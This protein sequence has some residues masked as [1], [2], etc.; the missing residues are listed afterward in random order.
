MKEK[1][2]MCLLQM[3]FGGS[4]REIPQIFCTVAQMRDAAITQSI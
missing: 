4:N 2:W 3:E 1:G